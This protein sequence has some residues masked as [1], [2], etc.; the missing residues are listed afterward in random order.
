MLDA[1]G[2]P[3]GGYRPLETVDGIAVGTVESP[4]WPLSVEVQVVRDGALVYLMPPQQID[5]SSPP[6]DPADGPPDDQYGLLMA[7]CLHARGFDVTPHPDGSFSYG[8][9]RGDVA[10]EVAYETAVRECVVELGFK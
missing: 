4:A 5:T 3:S 7:E 2:T 6:A 8:A 10:V 9:A 1:D